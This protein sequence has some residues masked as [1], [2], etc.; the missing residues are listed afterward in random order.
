[1]VPSGE[2]ICCR[3]WRSAHLRLLFRIRK[4]LVSRLISCSVINWEIMLL[5]VNAQPS[6][7]PLALP[8]LLRDLK[9]NEL[10]PEFMTT[11]PERLANYGCSQNISMIELKNGPN[12]EIEGFKR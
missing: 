8:P 5:A 12:V 7:Q 2:Q 1:M 10:V 11:F 9:Q 3:K 6:H 4:R